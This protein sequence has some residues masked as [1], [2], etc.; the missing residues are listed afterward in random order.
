MFVTECKDGT[1]CVN[2]VRVYRTEDGQPSNGPCGYDHVEPAA[3]TWVKRQSTTV[4]V[5]SVCASETGETGET[6]GSPVD[7]PSPSTEIVP[8]T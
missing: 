1:L 3:G 8:T 7:E 2:L 5:V 6:G 4:Y